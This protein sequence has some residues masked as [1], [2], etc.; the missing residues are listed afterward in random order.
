MSSFHPTIFLSPQSQISL[1]IGSL[2]K[3][4]C[5]ITEKIGYPGNKSFRMEIYDF[6]I[7]IEPPSRSDLSSRYLSLGTRDGCLKCKKSNILLPWSADRQE[8]DR[9]CPWWPFRHPPCGRRWQRR[10][11]SPCCTRPSP[12]QTSRTRPVSKFDNKWNPTKDPLQFFV[13]FNNF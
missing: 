3:P 12:D 2:K 1:K 4:A 8:F 5:F 13:V 10:S 9:P 11:P 7:S 6:K